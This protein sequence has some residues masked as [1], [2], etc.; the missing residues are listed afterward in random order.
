MECVQRLST[1]RLNLP[2]WHLWCIDFLILIKWSESLRRTSQVS[3]QFVSE[4]LAALEIAL[5]FVTDSE[6]NLTD[7]VWPLTSLQGLANSST[8]LLG[9]RG[10]PHYT[11]VLHFRRIGR[12]DGRL[13]ADV[14]NSFLGQT[15]SHSE[16]CHKGSWNSLETLLQ[17]DGAVARRDPAR[18]CSWFVVELG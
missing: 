13:S 4:H 10:H 5:T 7:D 9:G 11:R 15:S 1:P 6:K 3:P 8:S 2:V 18:L 16:V 17:L 12:D 14:V